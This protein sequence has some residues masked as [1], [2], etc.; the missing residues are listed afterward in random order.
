MCTGIFPKSLVWAQQGLGN[1]AT[2]G[3]ASMRPGEK[4]QV[5]GHSL[6]HCLH[7]NE[8]PFSGARLPSETR[9]ANLGRSRQEF[10]LLQL[11]EGEGKGGGVD[12]LRVKLGEAREEPTNRVVNM[13]P[14]QSCKGMM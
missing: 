3:E 7:K 9:T 13:C 8:S 11:T 6:A 5:T 10:R 4:R 1:Y 2:K 14:I 12:A